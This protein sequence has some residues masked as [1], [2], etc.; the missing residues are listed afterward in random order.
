MRRCCE[1]IEGIGPELAAGHEVGKVLEGNAGRL[2]DL[3]VGLS[4]GGHGSSQPAAHG[5]FRSR[6]LAGLSSLEQPGKLSPHGSLYL[7]IV[8]RLG[9]DH[10][11][12]F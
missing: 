6:S 11:G 1:A 4:H 5:V 7:G 3:L 8:R 10:S 9:R 12:T 2:A